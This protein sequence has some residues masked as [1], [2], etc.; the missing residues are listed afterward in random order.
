MN[1]DSDKETVTEEAAMDMGLIESVDWAGELKKQD[2]A[3]LIRCSRRDEDSF[4]GGRKLGTFRDLFKFTPYLLQLELIFSIGI[5]DCYWHSCL[6]DFET[7]KIM[8]T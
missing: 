8:T 5:M 1:Y 3:V 4:T 6:N 7:Q 2:E